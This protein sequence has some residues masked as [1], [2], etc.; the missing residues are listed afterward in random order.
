MCFCLMSSVL[1]RDVFKHPRTMLPRYRTEILLPYHFQFVPHP[2][3]SPLPIFNFHVH[4]FRLIVTYTS[5]KLD[6]KDIFFLL[7]L[8]HLIIG[9]T[10]QNGKF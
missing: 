5:P 4:L 9:D 7:G 3:K 10:R 8:F 6:L 1:Y 2:C